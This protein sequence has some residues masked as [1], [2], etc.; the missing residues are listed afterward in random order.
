MAI[1]AVYTLLKFREFSEEA[2]WM[3]EQQV[4]SATKKDLRK[5]HE[6]NA[7][8]YENLS[9]SLQFKKKREK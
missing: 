9:L 2:D 6:F 1:L 7:N 4:V 8:T 3:I 5:I